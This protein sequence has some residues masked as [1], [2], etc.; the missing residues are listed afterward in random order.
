M[1]HRAFEEEREWRL[2]LRLHSAASPRV[3]HRAGHSMLVPYIPVAVGT[4]ARPLPVRNIVI[5]PTPHSDLETE[6][7]KGL[8]RQCGIRADVQKSGIPYRAL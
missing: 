2:V 1:K 4:N 6:A 7:V 8:C 3:R 5:G